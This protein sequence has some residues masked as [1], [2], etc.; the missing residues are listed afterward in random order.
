MVF[1]SCSRCER[2]HSARSFLLDVNEL[3][4]PQCLKKFIRGIQV[5]RPRKVLDIF[6]HDKAE[7]KNSAPF[8][9]A[10]GY[11]VCEGTSAAEFGAIDLSGIVEG[12]VH[13]RR[14]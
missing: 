7:L 9:L 10:K 5:E 4:T 3:K 6:D 14:S 11:V 12:S 2:L 8:S 13:S 1:N